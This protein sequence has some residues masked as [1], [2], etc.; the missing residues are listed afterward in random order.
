MTTTSNMG[1]ILPEP[2][3]TAGPAWA[4]ELNAAL[5]TLDL[6]DHSSGKGAKVTPAG[7]NFASDLP[8]S[9][10]KLT[11]CGGVAL[12]SL[13]GNLTTAGL[14]HIKSGDLYHVSSNGT[15]VQITSG[16]GLNLAS[17]GTIGGD[18]GGV[19][20]TAAASYTDLLKTFSWLQDSGIAAKMFMGDIL[21]THPSASQ[22]SVTLK[23]QSGSAAYDVA[24]PL[25][26]PVSN[27]SLMFANTSGVNLFKTL[28]GTTN[29]I[30][31]TSGAGTMTFALPQVIHT[32]ATPTFAG[33]TL[34]GTLGGTAATLSGALTAGSIVTAG[35]VDGVDVSAFKT[36]YDAKVNQDV[37]TTASPTFV[38]ATISG[39]TADTVVT[40]NSSKVFAS[41]AYVTAATPNTIPYRDASGDC[42]FATVTASAV[43]ASGV[44][45]AT[46]GLIAGF[47]APTIKFKKITATFSSGT[48]LATI[49]HGLTSTKI[50]S[51]TGSVGS[52]SIPGRELG[53]HAGVSPHI[54]AMNYNGTNILI[55]SLLDDASGT[56]VNLTSN[57]DI[58]LLVTYEA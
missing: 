11:D 43:N 53:S 38:G 22:N 13:A 40:T 47:A 41:R 50:L 34:T 46:G 7:F 30:T 23:A 35:T 54:Y 2:G 4:T 31:V 49:A 8:C 14:L 33:M 16:T 6:H 3:V 25:A 44:V 10:F 18:Y 21:L 19:G 5:S 9:G 36:D 1:L 56:A 15:A 28:V 39:L 17:T 37:K 51:I 20:I 57:R 12:R 58:I 29:Q 32:A 24:F 42:S 52:Y 26:A 27:D 55:Q 48:N 45:T